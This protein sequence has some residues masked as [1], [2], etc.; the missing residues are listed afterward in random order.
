MSEAADRR[1]PMTLLNGSDGGR[2]A[3][4]VFTPK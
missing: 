3:D 1:R 2:D 4:T